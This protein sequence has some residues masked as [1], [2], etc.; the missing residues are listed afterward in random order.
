MSLELNHA[1]APRYPDPLQADP[2]ARVSYSANP[3]FATGAAE[4]HPITSARKSQLAEPSVAEALE[5][6][7]ISGLD[8][9]Q[10]DEFGQL[11][12]R[13]AVSGLGRLRKHICEDSAPQLKRNVIETKSKLAAMERSQQ[14]QAERQ[15]LL[16]EQARQQETERRAAAKAQEAK[17]ALQAAEEAR[18]AECRAELSR[19]AEQIRITHPELNF[20]S[21]LGLSEGLNLFEEH[22]RPEPGGPIGKEKR[23]FQRKLAERVAGYLQDP[24]ELVNDLS[25]IRLMHKQSPDANQRPT[26]FAYNGVIAASISHALAGS[27]YGIHDFSPEIVSKWLDITVAD[28]PAAEVHFSKLDKFLRSDPKRS[29]ADVF[30]GTPTSVYGERILANSLKEVVRQ[31]PG[32]I[33]DTMYM[34]AQE[35]MV[36]GSAKHEATTVLFTQCLIDE[37]LATAVLHLSTMAHNETLRQ[38]AIDLQLSLSLSGLPDAI[39]GKGELGLGSVDAKLSRNELKTIRRLFVRE[40]EFAFSSPRHYSIEMDEVRDGHVQTF[41]GWARTHEGASNSLYGRLAPGDI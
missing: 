22:G 18:Q 21:Y 24:R 41:L 38:K 20:E 1:L 34:L 19:T 37:P 13:L 14:Q 3:A 40:L 26:V 28:K 2:L 4:A 30:I 33:V 25:I 39:L 32:R 17:Q 10:A 8:E 11:D 12:F 27:H 31:H 6:V 15:Q 16:A 7:Y 23:G 9:G 36:P 5:A 35:G 29:V